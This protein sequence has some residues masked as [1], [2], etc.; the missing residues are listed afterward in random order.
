MRQGSVL[1]KHIVYTMY[2]M[3]PSYMY[4]HA[5][6]HAQKP[7]EHRGFSTDRHTFAQKPYEHIG[8]L[9]CKRRQL[10]LRGAS[11]MPQSPSRASIFVAAAVAAILALP[12][13][14]VAL[15][16]VS[17]LLCIVQTLS[18]QPKVHRG[19][20]HDT[21]MQLHSPKGSRAWSVYPPHLNLRWLLRWPL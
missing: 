14:F 12:L 1:Y 8:F 15:C 5:R 2:V 19:S 13:L 11:C 17:C 7:Y 6:I 4:M 18:W 3:H 9:T 16:R 10:S 21:M 20:N